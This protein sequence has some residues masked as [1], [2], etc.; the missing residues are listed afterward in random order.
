MRTRKFTG[1]G[2][3]QSLGNIRTTEATQGRTKNLE[4]N[5][6]RTKKYEHKVDRQ[7]NNIELR[8]IH[9]NQ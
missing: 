5:E 8:I 1:R 6:G 4:N 7:V 9:Q 3:R 2:G